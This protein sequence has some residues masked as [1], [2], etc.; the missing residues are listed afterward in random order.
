MSVKKLFK[1][2]LM[3]IVK[4]IVKGI[5]VE[6]NK[7]LLVLSKIMRMSRLMLPD[8]ICCIAYKLSYEVIVE[9]NQWKG[10]F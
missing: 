10:S 1:L 4:F 2:V 7:Q 3:L 8:I 5:A 9:V 6:T